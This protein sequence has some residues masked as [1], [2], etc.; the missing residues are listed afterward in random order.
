[1]QAR[2]YVCESMCVCDGGEWETGG[3]EQTI[4]SIALQTSMW[5]CNI[6]MLL[7]YICS[8]FGLSSL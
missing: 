1:M 2:K 8:K 4:L 5:L 6:F 7:F 3:V